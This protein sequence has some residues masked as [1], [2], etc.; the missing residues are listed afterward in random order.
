M[1]GSWWVYI[2]SCADGTLY[3]GVTTDVERRL[4]EHNSGHGAK[5]TRGRLPATLIYREPAGDKGAALRR[6]MEIKGMTRSD[7]LALIENFR[8]KKQT[9]S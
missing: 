3:T 4:D 1:S 9:V 2:L 5:Y 7:K 6:E 8:N